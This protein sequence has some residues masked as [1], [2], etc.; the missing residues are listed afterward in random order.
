EFIN[1]I[2]PGAEGSVI[3]DLCIDGN[4]NG[5]STGTR[6]GCGI[7]ATTTARKFKVLN[8]LIKDCKSD[9]V[10]ANLNEVDSDLNIIGNRFENN[11]RQGTAIVQ[12]GKVRVLNITLI[13]NTISFEAQ[14][15][16]SIHCRDVLIDG[17][18]IDLSE[19]SPY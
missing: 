11:G 1:M 10:Y 17:N 8:C 19:D 2:R 12:A 9:G 18:I 6:E 14:A 5:D 7:R 3:R 4:R 13:D 15:S 16:E